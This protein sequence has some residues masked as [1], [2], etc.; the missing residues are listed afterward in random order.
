MIFPTNGVRVKMIHASIN[1]AE[2]RTIR[3]SRSPGPSHMT[4]IGAAIAAFGPHRRRL[5][6]P[7]RDRF[8]AQMRWPW[9][10]ALNVPATLRSNKAGVQLTSSAFTEG[11]LNLPRLT[12]RGS[13]NRRDS[14]AS[15][16]RHRDSFGSVLHAGRVQRTLC[17]MGSLRKCP[18]LAHLSRLARLSTVFRRPGGLCIVFASSHSST[19]SAW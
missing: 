7:L 12:R 4:W 15:W 6:P 10:I 3:D 18:D 17:S 16:P 13:H 19:R 14:I 5:R 11:C 2:P 8:L 1:S 9:S